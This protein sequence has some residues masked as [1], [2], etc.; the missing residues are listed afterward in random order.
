MKLI[1]IED[2]DFKKKKIQ[3]FIH[4]NFD[5]TEISTAGAVTSGIELIKN[6]LDDELILLDMSLPTYDNIQDTDAGRPQGFGGIEILRYMEFIEDNRKVIIITQFD[7]FT[8]DGVNISVHDIE[9][10]LSTEFNESFIGLVQFNVV[11]D[12]WKPNLL[13]KINEA[14]KC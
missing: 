5:D 9:R 12:S 14:L 11:S 4:E 10:K 2:D 1:L 3:N 6:N 8:I 7:N 13:E